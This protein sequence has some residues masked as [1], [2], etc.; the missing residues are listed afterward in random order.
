MAAKKPW[1]MTQTEY[2]GA[3]AR[4]QW[5][6]GNKPQLEGAALQNKLR[7]VYNE[8][9][10]QIVLQALSEGKSVPSRVLEAYPDIALEC[11]VHVS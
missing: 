9:H 8:E 3:V 11:T 4:K 2:L 10:R 6:P 5:T 1:Q 7:S